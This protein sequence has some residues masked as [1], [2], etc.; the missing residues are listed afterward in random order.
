MKFRDIISFQLGIALVGAVL[1][2][3]CGI[4]PWE[5]WNWNLSAWWSA[6][7]A[8][9]PVL[10]FFFIFRRIRTGVLGRFNN[11][12]DDHLLPL[13]ANTTTWQFLVISA[14]AGLGEEL[15][16]RGWLQTWIGYSFLGDYGAL[17]IV[18]IIFG[19]CHAMT[20]IYFILATGIG[21]YL[22]WLLLN[23]QN[24]AQPIIVHGLYDAMA[25]IYLT[26]FYKS[27]HP[28]ENDQLVA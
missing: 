10:I 12:T 22:G 13:F 17:I 28:V 1:C 14:L 4:T 15:F 18:S 16:F 8:T 11:W 26:R 2:W 9:L 21:L 5:T 23:T 3:I 27:P 7:L 19:L 24:L 20:W 6:T 25:L